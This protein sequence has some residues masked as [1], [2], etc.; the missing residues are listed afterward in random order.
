MMLMAEQ[1][2]AVLDAFRDMHV[3]S[4]RGAWGK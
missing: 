1:G 3:V 2:V 4:R